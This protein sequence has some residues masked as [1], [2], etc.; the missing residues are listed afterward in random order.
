[1]VTAGIYDVVLALGVEK[2][3]HED[4]RKTFAAFSG[5]VDVEALR[6]IL[7]SLQ[8]AGRGRRRE[9]PRA[10]APARSARCSWTSTRR[11]RATTWSATAP[12]SSS[13]P[14]SRRRTRST[15]ASIRAPS[16]ARP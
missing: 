15:A 6:E 3:Y 7:D 12:P 1:M 4:K 11:R 14:L 2:L 13:S 16:S 10:R 5:A 9:R 8:G